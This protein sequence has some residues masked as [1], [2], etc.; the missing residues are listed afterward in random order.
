MTPANRL[1]YFLKHRLGQPAGVRVVSRAMVAVEQNEALSDIV[2][3][4]MRERRIL[5]FQAERRKRQI[6]SDSSKTKE[7]I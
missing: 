3:G 7:S 4:P 5:G 6:M 1:K 2:R